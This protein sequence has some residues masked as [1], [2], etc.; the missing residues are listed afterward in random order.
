MNTAAFSAS[1]WQFL[2]RW[3]LST[4]GRR[5]SGPFVPIFFLHRSH[6]PQHGISGITPDYLRRCL[7]WIARMGYRFISIPELVTAL[8]TGELPGEPCVAF[9][10]D[11]GYADQGDVLAPV[12]LEHGCPVTWFL[13]T[14]LVDGLDWPWDDKVAWLVNN[15]QVEKFDLEVDGVVHSFQPRA[16]EL[17]Q[18]ARRMI[19]TLLKRTSG[20]RIHG[21]IANLAAACAMDLPS[22][23]PPGYEPTTWD[24]VRDLVAQGLCVGAHSQSHRILSQLPDRDCNDEIQGSWERVKSQVDPGYQIFCYPTGQDGDFGIREQQGLR[25]LGFDAGLCSLPSPLIIRRDNKEIPLFALPR[26]ELP[27]HFGTF[28][29][30][31]SWFE[32]LRQRLSSR[33]R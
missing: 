1:M 26:F 14:D 23:P 24:R 21:L 20:I 8:K 29:R 11:D 2:A 33:G 27:T 25:S 12:F 5:L 32:A 17:R 19:R 18:Q 30:Y 3:P 9:C 7:T 4:V 10:M 6:Q 31:C 13:I 15:T 16:P 22:R 28:V